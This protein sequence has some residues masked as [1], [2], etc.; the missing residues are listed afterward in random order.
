M[1]ARTPAKFLVLTVA[2]GALSAASGARAQDLPAAAVPYASLSASPL[3]PG[4]TNG[5]RPALMAAQAGDVARAS[6]LRDGLTDPVARKLVDWAMIDSSGASLSFFQLDAARRDLW[7]WP[8]EARRR[9]AAERAVET[10]AL[11]PQRVVDWFADEPPQTAEGVMALAAAYQ[12]LGRAADAEGL[13]RK[14]WRETV[15]ELDAQSRMLARFGALLTPDDHAK[16]LDM[17]LYGPQGPAAKAM[18]DLVSPE[19]RLVGEARMAFRA[20]RDDANDTLARTPPELQNEPGLAFERARYLRRRDL[21]SAAAGLVRYFPTPPP[22]SSA[23]AM[24]WAERRALMSAAMRAGDMAGAYAA[25]DEHNLPQGADYAEAEFFAGWLA[26]SKLNN[27]ALA[28]EHFARVQTAGS[29]PITVSRAFYWR[30][31]AAEALGDMDAAK[32]FWTQGAKYY[33]AFYGQLSAGKI[34]LTTIS[35]PADPTPSAADRARFEGRDTVRAAKMLLD[36]GYRD[37]FRVFL[38]SID[39]VVP[40]AEELALLVDMAT[41]SG[42]QDLAMRVVRAGAQRGLYLPERGYPVRA[43]PLGDGLPEPALTFAIVRQE[44]GFDARVRSGVGARGMMQLMPSTAS[45]VARKMG[46][47]YSPEKLDD[48]DYN[49]HLGAAYL[50]QLVSDF[51]GSYVMAAAGYN[52]GPGR[53]AQWIT[54]CGDPRSAS[55]DPAD[56][57]ECIPFSET[58]NY[59]MRILEATSVYRARLNG[60]E[61]PLDLAADLKRGGYGVIGPVAPY[62]VASIAPLPPAPPRAERA[63]PIKV[64]ASAPKKSRGKKLRSNVSAACHDKGGSS[65]KAGSGSKSKAKAGSRSRVKATAKKGGKSASAAGLKDKA[66]VTRRKG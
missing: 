27:P 46:V 4:A 63:R 1:M 43:A 60:G 18:F 38:L 52:A 41:A 30:G 58:R 45:L 57:I 44:S 25:I 34:G 10:A 64:C 20:N 35:L 59:V 5:L 53:P 61:A 14:A 31:R 50:G 26:L 48:P 40:S 65:A 36:A 37:L 8:R 7:G 2:L 49:M 42:D 15:F 32:R 22:Q 3:P 51:S 39:D 66:K 55:T 24:I 21:E 16:R 23:A 17:L 11:A 13:V 54:Q 12:Q 56:F 62:Q 9:A 6:L 28:A 47:S 33:T 19:Q 29:S